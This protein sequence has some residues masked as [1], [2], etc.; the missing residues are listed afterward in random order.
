MARVEL[1]EQEQLPE[2]MRW[3]FDRLKGEGGRVGDIFKVHAHNAQILRGSMILGTAI[4]QRSKL[5][6]KLRELAIVRTGYLTGADYEYYAHIRSARRVGVTDAE[7]E[8]VPQGAAAPV[9][10]EV[11]KAVLAYTDALTASPPKIDDTLFQRVR[12]HLSEQEIVEL[13][14]TVGY[15]NMLGRVMVALNVVPEPGSGPHQSH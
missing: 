8:A 4:L 13:S 9:F 7:I 5:D 14:F 15:Y 12:S 1:L 2:D 6:A 10:G 3:L 11:Q